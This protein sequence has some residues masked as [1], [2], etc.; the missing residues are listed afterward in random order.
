VWSPFTY[1]H[2]PG[3]G[4]GE[5]GP[6]I[7]GVRPIAGLEG[8][9]I[10]RLTS[11]LPFS[12]TDSTGDTLVGLPNSSRLPYNSTLDLL[13]RR[14]LTVGRMRGGIY[15]DVRNLLDRRNIVAVRKDTGEPGPDN[16]AVA[17]LAQQA[18]DAHPEP[19]QYESP[20]YRKAGDL[21]SN[22]LIEGYDELFPL[23]LAAARDL[24]T[25]IFAHGPPRLVRLGVEFLF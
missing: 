10:F 1:G 21:D 17:R 12:R 2:H 5:T 11:G 13:I 9:V 7:L 25:P 19:I 14:A 23:Y 24:T 18:Y 15:L 20:R 8:A 16:T 4:A 22:G 3:E 6:R